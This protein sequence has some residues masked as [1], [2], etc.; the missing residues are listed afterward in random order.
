[1]G[2]VG[3]GS[4]RSRELRRGSDSGLWSLTGALNGVPGNGNDVDAVDKGETGKGRV[5]GR[6]Y[7]YV[8][9]DTTTSYNYLTNSESRVAYPG[10]DGIL[11]ADRL[12]LTPSKKSLNSSVSSSKLHL[13]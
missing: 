10:L 8:R 11:T 6:G 9:L 4:G 7:F 2:R 1:M 3:S 5:G 13:L 12:Q